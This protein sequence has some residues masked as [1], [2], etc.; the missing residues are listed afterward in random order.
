MLTG[1]ACYCCMICQRG[2][3]CMTA[4]P[5][6]PPQALWRRVTARRPQLEAPVLAS[7]TTA[8]SHGLVATA[9]AIWALSQWD[10]QSFGECLGWDGPR[11]M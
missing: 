8:A 2:T 10:W 4:H 6:L 7:S 9:G 3:L 11:D 1:I 5:P